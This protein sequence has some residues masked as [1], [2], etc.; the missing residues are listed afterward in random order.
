MEWYYVWWLWLTTKCVA[1]VCQHQLSFLLRY[2]TTTESKTL[3]Q[4]NSG[5]PAVKYQFNNYHC[6]G[7]CVCLLRAWCTWDWRFCRSKS[8]TT[9]NCT[10]VICTPSS[11]RR[12]VMNCLSFIFGCFFFTRASLLILRVG[13]LLGFLWLGRQYTGANDYLQRLV[14][15]M[16]Y[17]VFTNSLTQSKGQCTRFGHDLR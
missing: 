12:T 8:V 5:N 7:Y 13:R 1:R 15:E 9:D 16:I 6:L 10:S 4:I 3:N 17:Y 2:A 11:Y 14:S